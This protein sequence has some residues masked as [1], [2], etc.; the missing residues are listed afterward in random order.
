MTAFALGVGSGKT[1]AVCE[2]LPHIP[3]DQAR[4]IEP[5]KSRAVIH[6]GEL[7]Q[8]E[9]CFLAQGTCYGSEYCPDFQLVLPY[10]GICTFSMSAGEWLLDANRSLL[11][12]PGWSSFG[13]SDSCVTGY[14]ATLLK[15]SRATID[16]VACCCGR[17]SL[18]RLG[19]RSAPSTMRLRLLT[20]Q[21][22]RI[23]DE[24]D[25]LRR[26]ECIVRAIIEAVG[27]TP[28]KRV[29]RSKAVDRAK[30]LLHA[31]A[32]ER[33]RLD[34]I[35]LEVGLTSVYLTQQFTRCEGIP[36][37]RYQLQL[38]LTRAL[39]ELPRCEDITNLALDLGFSSH[40]H[41]TSAFREAFGTTPSKY[42]L[43]IGALHPRSRAVG[44]T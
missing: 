22:L 17:G 7:A 20:Q 4:G 42:R 15:F 33:L 19:S 3:I 35:A 25:L 14:A 34:E 9:D 2:A 39:L 5:R 26:D 40:S 30:E 41:F 31:R 18:S 8:V 21:L 16:Q 43:T 28:Q 6:R 37:Y 12:A 10:L 36:L 38:R 29:V 32:G 13:V 11:L 27:G 1:R 23:G 24:P 44:S